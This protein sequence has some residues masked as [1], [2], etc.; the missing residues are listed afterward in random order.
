MTVRNSE[1]KCGRHPVLVKIWRRIPHDWPSFEAL[2]ACLGQTLA[3]SRSE[4]T[5]ALLRRRPKEMHGPENSYWQGRTKPAKP[6][7]PAGPL[8]LKRT[9]LPDKTPAPP[10]PNH[11][12][13]LQDLKREEKI[14]IK[15]EAFEKIADWAGI[16]SEGPSNPKPK[17]PLPPE[18]QPPK[19]SPTL[20]Q[21]QERARLLRAQGLKATVAYVVEIQDSLGRPLMHMT[22]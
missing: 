2:E 14:E 21:A 8:R 5:P 10:R 18:P 22:T 12:K 15:R 16:N 11:L 19:P 20:A 1:Q 13:A 6:P 9:A 17:M 3:E 4:K 7:A